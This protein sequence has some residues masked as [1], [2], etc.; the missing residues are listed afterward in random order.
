M[1]R[2]LVTGASGFIGAALVLALVAQGRTVRAAYRRAPSDAPTGVE[3]SIVG[4]LGADCDWRTALDDVRT[5]V[6][7]AGPAH[8]RFDEAQ[9]RRAIVDGTA[10][11]AAQAEAAGVSRFLYLSSI[12]AVAE[13]SSTPLTE[14]IAPAPEEAYGRAKLDAE[15]IV[16]AH[17]AL[18]PVILRPPLVHGVGA[19]ANFKRLLDLAESAWPLPLGGVGNVRNFISLDTLIAAILAVLDNDSAPSG[20]FHV[21]DQPALSTTEIVTALR[22]G[23]G[24]TPGLFRAPL[25][26][27]LAPRVLRQSLVVDDARFR[28][29]FGLVTSRSS[30]TLLADTARRWKAQR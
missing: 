5:V 16:L 27:A 22:E 9:L 6:H 17:A 12:K 3:T 1:A 29:T 23:L 14:D 26:M 7:L 18:R 11:L 20:V 15:R 19:K 24:R 30:A 4:D 2:V 28:A 13:R 8:A 21:A 10:T 25:V